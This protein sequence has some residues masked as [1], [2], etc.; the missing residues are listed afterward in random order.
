MT[1]SKPLGTCL[2]EATYRQRQLEKQGAVLAHQKDV[3]DAVAH[4]QPRSIQVDFEV[5]ESTRAARR[6]A[7]DIPA[8]CS[9]RRPG[10]ALTEF[11]LDLKLTTEQRPMRRTRKSGP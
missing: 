9:N 1:F 8:P 5:L 2:A 10:V 3:E 11:L 7:D 6:A 4:A